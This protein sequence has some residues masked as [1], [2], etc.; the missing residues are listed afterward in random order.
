VRI[1]FFNHKYLKGDAKGAEGKASE[2]L[3]FCRIK[4]IL[5]AGFGR[6]GANREKDG[7]PNRVRI[8]FFNH[9]YL[10][11]DAKGA[12]GKVSEMLLFCRIKLILLAGFG[13]I[14]V[15]RRNNGSQE[16]GKIG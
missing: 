8:L 10:K 1:L 11:G 4:L 2:M 7:S 15:N 14:G 9:K 3:L 5:F 12:E 13:R 16:W 6:I